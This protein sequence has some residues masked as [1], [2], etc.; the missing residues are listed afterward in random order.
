M[1]SYNDF[2]AALAQGIDATED[3][4]NNGYYIFPLDALRSE[5]EILAKD[6]F[7]P[8]DGGSISG[9]K[10]SLEDLDKAVEETNILYEMYPEK[11]ELMKKILEEIEELKVNKMKIDPE[12]VPTS[13]LNYNDSLEAAKEA[14]RNKKLVELCEE[15]NSK[16]IKREVT[17]SYTLNKMVKKLHWVYGTVD[18]DGVYH[19]KNLY[20]PQIYSDDGMSS[21]VAPMTLDI[22]DT[23]RETFKGQTAKGK[24]LESL[25]KNNDLLMRRINSRGGQVQPLGDRPDSSKRINSVR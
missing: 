4:F 13:F 6:K 10:D 21:E 3:A 7:F 9:S 2:E 18:K 16:G 11:K 20:P 19:I 22:I 5:L 12:E 8:G 23:K 24:D 15:H 17:Y 25:K 14:Y 1:A